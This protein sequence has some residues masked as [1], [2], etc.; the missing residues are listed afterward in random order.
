NVSFP[1]TTQGT[2]VVTWTFDDGNGNTTTATQ[3]IVVT[4]IATPIASVTAQP[5]CSIPTATVLLS[6]LPAG[7]WTINPGTITGTGSTT[8]I[9]GLAA[10]ATYNFTVASAGGCTSNPVAVTINSYVCPA[11]DS[12][13][14][15][16]TGGTAIANV[17]SNDTTN[18][19]PS[20]TA[21][22]VI[23]ESG[24]W[25]AGISLNT[26]T[27]AITVAAGT[28][29]GVY[30]VTYQLCDKL[31]PSACATATA[32]ITIPLVAVES[33]SISLV[34]SA[35]LNDEDGNGSTQVGETISYTL[36]VTNTGNVALTNAIVKDAMLGFDTSAASISLAVGENKEYQLSYSITQADIDRA[37]VVNT[38]SATADSPAAVRVSAEDTVNTG[39]N[40]VL[41]ESVV[42]VYNAVSPNGDGFNDVLRIDGLQF[43]PE[44]TVEIYNRWGV[45]VFERDRYNNDDRAFRG[46]S[47]GRVTVKQ[48]EELPTGTYFYILK[49]K[50]NE[51]K[52]YE[53]SGYLYINR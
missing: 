12:G 3:N 21:N 7:N 43:Y 17:L 18:G 27:G 48:A 33:P 10:G 39:L 16:S 14:A 35:V 6:G 19:A 8:T 32:T 34:K 49:Y 23:S 52:T 5:T 42:K 51:K 40:L 1:I 36:L 26:T 53:K 25:P 38:A 4:G 11:A 15:P 45:L 30:N 9:S 20:T 29:A 22:S 50:D 24:S 28:A 31:A 13:T 2:T 47:E 41:P 46:R 37:E 44:N